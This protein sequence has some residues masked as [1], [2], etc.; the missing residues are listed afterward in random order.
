M[1][2]CK[3]V[4]PDPG[5]CKWNGGQGS[6][7]GMMHL[8]WTLPLRGRIAYVHCIYKPDAPTSR[9]ASGYYMPGLQP[10]DKEIPARGA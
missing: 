6:K 5:F 3:A 9:S 2:T 8:K 10:K 7:P 4:C 1:A